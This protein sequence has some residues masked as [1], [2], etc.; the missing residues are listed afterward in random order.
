[1]KI[2][3][4]FFEAGD[5]HVRLTYMEIIVLDGKIKNSLISHDLR[6]KKTGDRTYDSN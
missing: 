5:L 3:V 4:V 6:R 1:M 2:F